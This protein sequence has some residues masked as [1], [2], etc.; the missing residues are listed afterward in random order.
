LFVAAVAFAVAPTLMLAQQPART[1][2]GRVVAEG[3]SDPLA[4]ATVQIV[5]ST[6]GAITADDGRYRIA[7]PEGA[8]QLSVRRIGFKRRTVDVPADRNTVD[9]ALERDALKL[10]EL[11]ITGQGTAVAR[12]NLANDVASV[13]AEALTKVQT[14]S[15]EGALQGKVPGANI[16]MN[17]GAPGGGGQVQIRGIT[18]INGSSDPLWVVDG[19]IVSND[20]LN[21]GLTAVT[22][23]SGLQPV[24][25]DNGVNR[26][27][28]LNLNDIERIE[29]LKGASAS[30]IYGARAANGVIVITTKKGRA[31]PPR[32]NIT[33]RG[34]T[35]ERLRTLG[36]RVFTKDAAISQF[37]GTGKLFGADT[38]GFLAAYGNGAVHDNEKN[39]FG[40]TPFSYETS[41]NASGG[42]EN[43][44]YFGSAL[45][46]YDGGIM[47]NTGAKRQSLRVNVSQTAGR[48]LNLDLHSAVMHSDDRRGLSNNDNTGTSPYVVFSTTPSFFDLRPKGGVFPTNPFERSNPFQT[49]ALSHIEESTDRF[50][51]GGTASYQ[52]YTSQTQTAQF[53]LDGGADRLNQNDNIYTPP[54]LQFEPNDGLSGTTAVT[55]GQVQNANLN[56]SLTHTFTPTGGLVQATTA[57]G[58]QR[59]LR[60]VQ[61][62]NVV[63]R[64][65]L[66]GQENINRG[67]TPLL[68]QNRQP[69]KVFA[70]FGQEELLLFNE[71]LLLTG[72]VRAERNTNNGDVDKLYYFPKASASYRLPALGFVNELKI[73]SAW[74]KSGNQPLYGTKFTNLTNTVYNNG[75]ALRVALGA[76]DPNI[77]PETQ[78]EIE[79]G[80]DASA[81]N[82]RATLS[83]T[84]FDKTIDD[85]I[86]QPTFAPSAGFTNYFTNGASLQNRGLESMLQITPV[87]FRRG[88]WNTT[89]IYQKVKP[90]ITEL[91]VPT[92]RQGG[93]ALFLGQYQVEEGKSPT[94]IVGLVPSKD[95]PAVSVPAIVGDATPDYQMSFNNEV[96]F[97]PFHASALLDWKHG[98]DVINL[99][100][101]LYDAAQNSA[102]WDTKGKERFALQ[103]KDTRPYV[104][105]GSFVK[106]R[107]VSLSYR[108]PES[109]VQRT[110]RNQVHTA[111]LSFAGRNLLMNSAY[112]G[113]DPEVSNFGNQA[114]N[115]NVDVAPF[116]P[117]RSFFLSL[118][119]G[120]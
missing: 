96:S 86:I 67:T 21:P 55:D 94:Q 117:S 108:L 82:G 25:Q 114:L 24:N 72:G 84:V 49:M 41:V 87:R 18:S 115:R 113:L 48:K 71:R 77:K 33:Q 50:I 61:F 35:Y 66:A 103:G 63:N 29:V 89:V 20:V 19:V 73:R 22:R 31:G 15:F 85:L 70:M 62:V 111:S 93:F 28:D 51:V 98:G 69:T 10:E 112:K 83:M 44:R 7:A 101:F 6:A 100:T 68:Q 104:E 14:T 109:F 40:E 90:K 12:Q 11:V 65:L 74:G 45:N 1:I 30:S 8:L 107:E 118:D 52:L 92:F 16:Q 17:S 105:D 91:T 38:A 119:I 110:F 102:D 54:E 80:F 23:S 47:P 56:A 59:E 88:E 60:E 57:I 36:S 78:T 79:G 46:K 2:T 4:G 99:T 26:I 97:G 116:P 3:G 9:V 53:R 81:F 27:A 120:F 75:N 106:L 39:F 64:D 95:N 34:G 43:T 13:D 58:V 42:G 76:G 37:L 5:G 32:F